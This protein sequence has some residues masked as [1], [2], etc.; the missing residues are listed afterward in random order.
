VP[1]DE[2]MSV[3][4]RRKYLRLVEAR[5]AK[6]DK[7]ERGQLLTEMGAVSVGSTGKA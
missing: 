3:D 1:N 7:I 2:K 4:E 6:A 5:Y